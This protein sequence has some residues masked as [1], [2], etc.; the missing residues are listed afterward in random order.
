MS[1]VVHFEIHA[2][3]PQRAANFYQEV[4]GWQIQKWDGPAEYWLVTTGK[5]P[6]PG[7]DGAILQRQGPINGDAVIAY[8]CTVDVA[9]VDDT[10]AKITSLGGTIA[11]PKMPVPGIGWL[12]YAKDIEGNIFGVMQS[13]HNAH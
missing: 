8:V 1:R 9:S 7:I 6:E 5:P 2:D 4:F 11:L 12:A 3:D 13:D 10:I